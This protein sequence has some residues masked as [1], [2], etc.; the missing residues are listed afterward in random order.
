MPEFF[1]ST[2][3][4]AAQTSRALKR[5]L[6]RKIG[7]RLYT[8]NLEDRPQEVV[9]R[10]LWAIVE[11]YAPGALVADRTA[12][13]MAPA[14]DGSVCLVSKLSREVELPGLRLR[15]RRGA[16][17][18]RG[19]VPFMGGTLRLSS[20]HR[21][22]LDNLQVSRARRGV[23]RTLGQEA[24]EAHME[25]V[26]AAAGLDAL[27]KLVEDASAI[28][29]LIDRNREAQRLAH[30]FAELSGGASG[31]LRSPLAKA[32]AAGTPYDPARLPLF[33]RLVGALRAV[34]RMEVPWGA[35]RQGE[36][37]RTLAFFDAYFSNYIEGTEL[38]V[39]EAV[40]IVFEARQPAQRAAEAQDMLGLW[41]VVSDMDEMGTTPKTP[42]ELLEILRRRHVMVMRGRPSAE[43]GRFKSV[44]DRIGA[45][46]FVAP[47]A[48]AGTLREG[49]KRLEALDRPFD[50]A[51]FMHFLVAEV[52]PFFD[53]NGRIARVMMNAELMAAGQHP[54]VIPTAYRENYLA[55]QRSPSAGNSPDPLPQAL[56]RAQ[57]WTAGVPW[58]AL[59]ATTEALARRNAFATE[60]EL[61]D[62]GLRLLDS[63]GAD[64]DGRAGAARR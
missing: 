40:G 58:G 64:G 62:L 46:E 21:A 63:P 3:A 57:R 19:D 50:R 34:P 38:T 24:V 36:A 17:P 51:V 14:Q 37:R 7:P 5:R 8:R 22:M 59:A 47:E 25:R 12:M 28:A 53:G 33:D 1:L 60:A 4:T 35:G 43:P 41:H 11:A 9:R 49:F 42:D 6:V 39:D 30:M 45:K 61:D 27:A 32:R 56:H 15:P 29:P 2:S 23:A 20:P 16:P 44:R 10:N 48:V 26:A 31:W 55:A 54:I 18:V 52:H 13:E